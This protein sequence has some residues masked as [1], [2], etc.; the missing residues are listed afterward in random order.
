[1]FL[2]RENF[3]AKIVVADIFDD[4]GPLDELESSMD[5]I[6]VGL[7][8]HLFDWEGQRKACERMVRM[9]KKQSGVLVLGHQFGNLNPKDIPF[10]TSQKVFRHDESSFERLWKEV[11]QNTGSQWTVKVTLDRGMGIA[12]RKRPWDD[13]NTRRMKFEVRRV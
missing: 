6:H 3:A 5:I 7:F 10:G 9:L 12:E 4:H 8:L 1:L 11:G 2:D 13:E